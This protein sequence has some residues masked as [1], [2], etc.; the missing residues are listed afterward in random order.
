[1]RDKVDENGIMSKW[2]R[3][4][5]WQS[6]FAR[7]M[8]LFVKDNNLWDY[9]ADYTSER[10]PITYYEWMHKNAIAAWE[11]RE[12][13][14]NITFNEWAKQTPLIPETG[15]TWT[16]MEMVSAVVMTQVT[17]DEKP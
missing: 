5:T 11:T 4:G 3:D 7:G 1:M 13:V 17:P 10:K 16:A 15:K 8:G 9:Q 12:R 6:E 2:H 14:N